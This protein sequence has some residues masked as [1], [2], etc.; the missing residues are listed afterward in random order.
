MIE[1]MI[2]SLRFETCHLWKYKKKRTLIHPFCFFFFFF[3]G[4]GLRLL[5]RQSCVGY[6]W[7]GVMWNI[8]CKS[9]CQGIF[10]SFICSPFIL[11]VRIVPCLRV[12]LWHVVSPYKKNKLNGKNK[13]NSP[14]KRCVEKRTGSSWHIKYSLC[15]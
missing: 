8:I 9:T 3:L 2:I 6:I 5:Y 15:I 12:L 7:F 10:R 1:M 14:D 13:K 11:P 4:H